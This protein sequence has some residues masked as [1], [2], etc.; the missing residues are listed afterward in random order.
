MALWETMPKP[1][2]AAISGTAIA[3]AFEFTLACD[4]RV[5]EDGDYLWCAAP[6][7]LP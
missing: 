1:V 5:A 7:T 2:I 6:W 4:L 3:G